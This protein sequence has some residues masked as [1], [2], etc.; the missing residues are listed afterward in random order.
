MK[1][2]K[3]DFARLTGLLA[4]AV[5]SKSDATSDAFELEFRYRPPAPIDRGTFATLLKYLRSVS[6]RYEERAVETSLDVSGVAGTTGEHY[7]ASYMLA[8]GVAPSG[9]GKESA[10]GLRALLARVSAQAASADSIIRKE[11]I[12][13]PVDLTDFDLRA[14]LSS[15]HPVQPGT[16]VHAMV[17]SA[18]AGTGTR[19]LR[20]KRRYSFA[21]RQEGG[22]AVMRFDLTVVR[23]LARVA[24]AAATSSAVLAVPE[25]YEVELERMGAAP[26]SPKE[27]SSML[28][29]MLGQWSVLLK[30]VGDTDIVLSSSEKRQVLEGYAR[31][32]HQSVAA[33][34]ALGPKLVTL[35]RRHLVDLV[36]YAVTEKA[37]GVHRL[38]YV[39]PQGSAYTIDDRLNV[40]A[41]GG[42]V[43]AP[44]LRPSLLEGEYVPKTSRRPYHLMLLFDAFYVGGKDVGVEALSQRLALVQAVAKSIKTDE[45]L[46]RVRPKEFIEVATPADVFAA[47]RKILAKRTAGNFEYD[48]DGLVFTPS[49][50]PLGTSAPGGAPRYTGTWA[51]AF[52]WKPPQFN[53]VDFL[54]RVRPSEAL[55]R[56]GRAF[57]AV[58]L[59]VAASVPYTRPVTSLM[60]MSNEIPVNRSKGLVPL[61]FQPPDRP[62]AHV[63]YLAVDDDG[64]MACEEGGEVLDDTIVEFRFDAAAQE[65]RALRNRDDKTERYL[66]SQDI[67]GTANKLETALSV[68]RSIQVPLTEQH[69]TGRAE[70]EGPE[71]SKDRDG[72]VDD[73]NANGDVY[74]AAKAAPRTQSKSIGLRT[75]HNRWVKGKHLLGRFHRKATALVDLGCGMAGDLPKWKAMQVKRVLGL[76]LYADN[77]RNPRDGA[78]VRALRVLQGVPP[79]QGVPRMAFLPMDLSQVIEPSLINAMDDRDGDRTAAQVLWGMLSPSAPVLASKHSLAKYLGMARSGFDLASCQ[80]AVH[81][82]FGSDMALD[83]FARNVAA[84][85]QPGGY[86]VGTCLDAFRVDR[87]LAGVA[88]GATIDGTVE[89]TPIWR[90]TRMYDRLDADD[91]S[92][93][94]GLKIRVYMESIGQALTEYLVD[95]RLLVAALER[96]SVHPLTP[97]ECKALGLDMSTGTF[98]ELF[99]DMLQADEGASP[100]MAPAR[101]MSEVEKRYSFLNRWF[102]FRKASSG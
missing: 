50:L 18:I 94:L 29:D 14:S 92:R 21:L 93:N 87:A 53:T 48:V 13:E 90:I 83:S 35:E 24:P 46:L 82:F 81:Y 42:K 58:D 2:G 62:D 47:A 39:D 98:E 12:A 40:R 4:A 23:Q 102:V 31:L 76:D 72:V 43:A 71:R 55:L 80:F 65:W 51:R 36:D 59:L 32:T 6:R 1:L 45:A 26:R 69:M 10:D 60:F 41:T 7:R 74:Y 66:R 27:A 100:D 34:R 57:K 73:A 64:R 37:D 11:R 25:T 88:K 52:K 95:F 3:D 56:G 89:G 33:C 61:L 28:L 99:A 97:V 63:A 44:A 86:F 22:K 78:H 79:A 101:S 16:D 15:E 70:L 75:F 9:S 54:V 38:L 85:L 20:F 68:W 30:V 91:A 96:V 17:C 84:F 5:R 49:K 8:V 77:L 67:G 19:T